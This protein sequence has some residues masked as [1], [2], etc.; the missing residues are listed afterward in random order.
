MPSLAGQCGG[1]ER[2]TKRVGMEEGGRA[3]LPSSSER[4][5]GMGGLQQVILLACRYLL[6]SRA[7]SRPCMRRARDLLNRGNKKGRQ[8]SAG[9]ARLRHF[10][11]IIR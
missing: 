6:R 7:A 8:H 11:T 10:P 9:V 5:E 3:A 4:Q 1:R 2:P